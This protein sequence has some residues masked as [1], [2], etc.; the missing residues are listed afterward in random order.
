M[1]EIFSGPAPRQ[2]TLTQSTSPFFL[3]S[4]LDLV[5]TSCTF[6][7][8]LAISI[9][10][11]SASKCTSTLEYLVSLTFLL[12]YLLRCDFLKSCRS[13][14]FWLTPPSWASPFHTQLA[15]TLVSPF[16]SS[17]QVNISS[18]LKVNLKRHRP[19][20]QGAR[21]LIQKVRVKR[22]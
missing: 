12:Y 4:Y 17:G 20:L 6:L 10:G 5:L 13:P 19:F 3:A 22:D 11:S 16:L 14:S 2:S 1:E 21:I 7:L 15:I 9:S 8:A 18:C